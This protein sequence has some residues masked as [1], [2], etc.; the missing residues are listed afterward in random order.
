MKPKKIVRH[1]MM[2]VSQAIATHD[3]K[4]HMNLISKNVKVYGVPGTDLIEYKDWSTQC[5]KEFKKRLVEQMR[6][7]NLSVVM[8]TDKQI[9]FYVNEV[10][11]ASSG[12]IYDQSVKAVIALEKRQWRITQLQVLNKREARQCGLLNDG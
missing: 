12:A 7:T 3:H 9:L 5:E 1:W 2:Q 10:I 4:A 8:M 11:Y 6:Y